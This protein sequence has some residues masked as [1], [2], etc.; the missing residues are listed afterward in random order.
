MT[1]R[2][3]L[4]SQASVFSFF[5]LFFFPPFHPLGYSNHTG[6]SQAKTSSNWEER[7]ETKQLIIT[8]YVVCTTLERWGTAC[9]LRD[10]GGGPGLLV[11]LVLGGRAVQIAL[12]LF[13]LLE[14]I[15]W[16]QGQSRATLELVQPCNCTNLIQA[17]QDTRPPPSQQPLSLR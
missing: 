8:S 9:V 14:Q 4:H 1:A 12:L 16:R 3:L 11:Q 6:K 15:P 2:P 10:T 17:S 7:W 13:K 5:P